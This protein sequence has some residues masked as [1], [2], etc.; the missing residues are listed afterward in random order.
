MD[1]KPQLAFIPLLLTGA[2]ASLLLIKYCGSTSYLP[3]ALLGACAV[4]FLSGALSVSSYRRAVK[5]AMNDIFRE[6]DTTAGNIIT[7]IAIPCVLFD[8]DGR[9]AWSN[10]AFS[11]LYS[12]RDIRRLIPDMDPRFPN[13]AQSIK[14]NGQDYQLMSMPVQRI[15]TETRLTFQYWLDRTE[16]LHYSRLYE[17]QMPTVGLIQ[18]DNYDDLMTDRQFHRNSV[19][20]DVER[21]ISDFVTGIDGV[22]RRYDN[23]KFFFVFEAKRIAE[24][25]QQR[26]TL[27]DEVREIDTGTGQPVTLSISIGVASRIAA[28]DEAARNGMQLVLGRGGDQAVVKKGTSY[29]FYGGKR[30]VTTRNS[31]VKARLFAEALRQ[32]MKTADAVF[33]MGHR[34]PDMDCVGAGVGIM[35]CA[36]SL[37]CPAYFV[38]DDTN[39]SIDGAIEAMRENKA[40]RETIKTPEQA[41]QMMHSSSLLIVVD[42]QR[43]SSLLNAELFDRAS[44][45]VVIDHHRRAADSIQNP[46]LNYLEPGSSSACEMVTEVIQYFEDG[47]KPTSFEAGALLAG[48]TM[49]TKH[50]SFNT[51]ARTFEAASYLRRNG[52]DNTTVKMMF[53][54]DMQTY[55]NRARVVENAIIMEQGIAISV[56]PAGMED[57]NLIAAQAADELVNIKGINASFVL[58]EREQ[59][60]YV[61]GRSLGDISVQLILERLGGGGHQSIA[62]AQ[63]RGVTM[64]EAISRLT[65]SINNYLKEAQEK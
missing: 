25:E 57:T 32:L 16:A 15:H 35:R 39:A 41:G 47:L 24:L 26:F 1:K 21:R 38:L 44:K 56:C 22:Y 31:R 8:G 14:Y 29:A 5:Y 11:A 54:D 19:L 59:V 50:F 58:A 4:F 7:N 27:L 60:I 2:A 52:A 43:K 45:V 28:S 9:I 48:I 49:D 64:D 13:K 10:E 40:Y 61:S 46:T 20:S 33:V 3:Y 63:M 65:E 17:E 23:S 51:G 62:G 18:V 53:Q 12:G 55:R 36:K 37:S 6:N 42:T 34:L 30:Q